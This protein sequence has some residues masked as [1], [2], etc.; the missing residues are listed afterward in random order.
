MSAW[1][2]STVALH[3]SYEGRNPEKVAQ[4]TNALAE[5]YIRENATFREQQ[6]AGTTEFLRGQLEDA[7]RQL[8]DQQR[9]ISEFKERHI[10]ELPEEQMTNLAALDRLNAKLRETADLELRA[11][12]RRD[13]LTKQL[14]ETPGT[15]GRLAKLKLDLANLRT[16]LT[17]EHPDVVA[18]QAQIAA[19]ERSLASAG[20]RAAPTGS[21]ERSLRD[22]LTEVEAELTALRK[23]ELALRST[24]AAYDQRLANAPRVV[25]EFEGLT[26]DNAVLQ[27][28]YRSLRQRYEDA[29][30]AQIAEHTQERELRLIEPAALPQKPVGPHRLALLLVGFVLSVGGA[31]GTVLLVETR[32]TSFHTVDEV[33]AFTG[34][35]VLV[36]IPPI[37]TGRDA[38]WRLLRAGF[39]ALGGVIGAVAVGGLSAY[40]ARS[41]EI[42]V[43]LLGRF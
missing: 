13:E 22:A 8:Q 25:Q 38:R 21:E 27:D 26:Q 15:P 41:S 28:R 12:G 9:Q 1:R 35:P 10:G 14:A 43:R 37:I 24:I 6:T 33:R 2:T 30:A 18:L 40:A 4:V 17:D 42:L 31:L 39:A 32:D 3:L 19:L 23:E 20:G 34:I 16:R 7:R 5:L 29:Q 11:M 36:S